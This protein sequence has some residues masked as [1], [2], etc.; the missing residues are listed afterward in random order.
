M[1]GKGSHAAAW[2]Q[3]CHGLE[4]R[5]PPLGKRGS[6]CTVLLLMALWIESGWIQ[7]MDQSGT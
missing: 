4:G 3:G 1:W 2:R 6:F 7:S 5:T